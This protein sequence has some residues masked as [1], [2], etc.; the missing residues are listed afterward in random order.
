M[1][2]TLVIAVLPL[3]AL[4]CGD[5]VCRV[6]PASLDLTKLITFDDQPSSWDPGNRIDELLHLQGATFAERFAGQTLS[7][8][9]DFDIVTGAAFPPLT[10]LP[11][12]PGQALSIVNMFQT[13]ILNGFGPAGYP[14]VHAQGEGAI[15]VMFD[16]DQPALGFTLLGGEN[17]QAQIQ[18][19]ARDG[20]I[21]HAMTLATD[22]TL[23]LGFQRA[24][25]AADIAGFVLTNTDPQ[26]VAIDDV[27][28]G[29]PP[30]LG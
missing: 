30:I 15:A 6:D 5:P 18:F 7:A 8:S 12:A 2:R 3:P 14:R 1:W 16:E 23:T 22:G 10:P 9:G 24:E 21:I 19:L 26:G 29:P 27:R 25:D 17:G 13:N 4:A 11:G 28:F 20:A